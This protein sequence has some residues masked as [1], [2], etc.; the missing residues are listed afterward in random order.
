MFHDDPKEASLVST[1]VQEDR[2]HLPHLQ[3]TPTGVPT[4]EVS[5]HLL[6]SRT[7]IH[8]LPQSRGIRETPETTKTLE[9]MTR[10]S[11]S[12]RNRMENG[13]ISDR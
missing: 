10:E 9:S 13:R 4:S 12:Y 1:A 5:L 3:R 8:L 7:T 2:S 11:L 6:L